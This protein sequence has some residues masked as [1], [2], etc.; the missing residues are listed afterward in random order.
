M[1]TDCYFGSV[2]LPYFLSP[3]VPGSG[4]NYGL[5]RCLSLE[6]K[7]IIEQQ[8][9][10]WTPHIL[11]KPLPVMAATYSSWGSAKSSFFRTSLAAF[12]FVKLGWW[13]VLQNL[14]EKVS[15]V[16]PKVRVQ[17]PSSDIHVVITSFLG[18]GLVGINVQYSPLTCSLGSSLRDLATY[19]TGYY[20]QHWE[21][22]DTV[23]GELVEAFLLIG[24]TRE[25]SRGKSQ[26]APIHSSGELSQWLTPVP[27]LGL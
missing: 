18:S 5:I 2:Q 13:T 3:E 19:E 1:T 16:G 23:V 11:R 4:E 20:Y 24:R 21:P 27:S 15:R 8:P 26:A 7:N 9:I 14:A 25:L 12:C 6:Y 10:W 17:F 22:R